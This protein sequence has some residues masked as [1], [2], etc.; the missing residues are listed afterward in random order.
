[1]IGIIILY[2]FV[3]HTD[4]HC[5]N[6][7]NLGLEID[8]ESQKDCF[9]RNSV[10]AYKKTEASDE[11]NGKQTKSTIFLALARGHVSF[12]TMSHRILIEVMHVEITHEEH[13]D[14]LC[15]ACD[16]RDQDQI[17][18]FEVDDPLHKHC[19]RAAQEHKNQEE[20]QSSPLVKWNLWASYEDQ[21]VESY[22][23][24]EGP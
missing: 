15:Q 7:K 17:N 13:D 14:D 24:W 23:N 18:V 19:I 20:V 8:N 12:I 2:L 9:P 10:I 5:V 3:F 21:K 16:C 1:M 6:L 11:N 22:E 4:D